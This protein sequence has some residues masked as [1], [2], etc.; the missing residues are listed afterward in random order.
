[1]SSKINEARFAPAP[2]PPLTQQE[3]QKAIEAAQF[4]SRQK[5]CLEEYKK[6]QDAA[7]NE[8]F[9]P[10]LAKQ[11]AEIDA[12]FAKT[13]ADALAKDPDYAKYMALWHSCTNEVNPEQGALGLPFR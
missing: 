8:R 7:Y 9:F 5:T 3:A 4:A 2:R 12:D 1:M 11:M 13:Y 10:D 6:K